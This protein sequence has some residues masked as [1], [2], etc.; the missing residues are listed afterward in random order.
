MHESAVT[1]NKTIDNQKVIKIRAAIIQFL[2]AFIRISPV[3]GLKEIGL[4]SV[5]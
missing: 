1:F 2:D 4:D 5:G 3:M